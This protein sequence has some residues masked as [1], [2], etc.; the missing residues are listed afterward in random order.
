MT[1][2]LVFFTTFEP[3]MLTQDGIRVMQSNGVPMVYSNNGCHSTDLHNESLHGQLDVVMTLIKSKAD[4][5]TVFLDHFGNQPIRYAIENGLL[6]VVEC[7]I[8]DEASLSKEIWVDAMQQREICS[9]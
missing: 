8:D 7:L 9:K 3:I 6:E 4:T 1:L 5:V 2:D